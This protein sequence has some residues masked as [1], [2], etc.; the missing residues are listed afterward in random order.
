MRE[1]YLWDRK[2]RPK[3]G[4]AV[5]PGSADFIRPS[6]IPA[7]AINGAIERRALGRRL[8]GGTRQPST[9]RI[10]TVLFAIRGSLA[11]FVLANGL[12]IQAHSLASAKR[13]VR[14]IAATT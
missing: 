5:V 14:A 9:V 12:S 1:R 2:E 3:L 8:G 6:V 10:P 4:F 11:R 13:V 7:P